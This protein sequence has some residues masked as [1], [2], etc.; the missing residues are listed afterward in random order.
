ME[1]GY[2][3]DSARQELALAKSL[4]NVRS[5]ID[6]GIQ[7]LN[8]LARGDWVAEH[9]AKRLPAHEECLDIQ[10]DLFSDRILRAADEMTRK[11]L[12]RDAPK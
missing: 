8:V 1:S 10:A 11:G 9:R 3:N 2:F 7:T 12:S 6:S 4:D 5:V